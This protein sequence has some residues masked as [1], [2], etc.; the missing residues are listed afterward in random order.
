M[1]DPDLALG[2]RPG[3]TDEIADAIEIVARSHFRG[4]GD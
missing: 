4:A 2:V 1:G 3:L